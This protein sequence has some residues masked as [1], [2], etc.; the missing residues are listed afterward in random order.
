MAQRIAFKVE[1]TVQG[2]NFR[3]WST[4]KASS[5]GLTGFVKNSEDRSVV[6]EAQ[7]D[8]GALDKFVQHLN[9]GPEAARVSR[10]DQKD[11]DVQ[12]NETEFKQ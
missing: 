6:G 7:G 1:G 9:M 10:V 2:V 12:N 8:R 3:A 5:L 4:Q 11:I